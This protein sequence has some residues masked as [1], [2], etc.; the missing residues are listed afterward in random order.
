MS[1][2]EIKAFTQKLEAG[3]KLAEKRMLEEKALRNE[4]VVVSTGGGEIQYIPAK[5]VLA[6]F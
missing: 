5:E 6:K 3:L 4:T 1:N 2:K